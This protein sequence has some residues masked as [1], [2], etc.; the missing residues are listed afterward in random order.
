MKKEKYIFPDNAY[1]ISLQVEGDNVIATYKALEFGDWMI[2]D[3]GD[4]D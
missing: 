4:L 3:F 2:A 1:N